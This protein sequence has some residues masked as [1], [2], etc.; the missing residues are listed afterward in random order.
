MSLKFIIYGMKKGIPLG[1]LTR[2]LFDSEEDAQDVIDQHTEYGFDPRYEHVELKIEKYYPHQCTGCGKDLLPRTVH[3]CVMNYR[4]TVLIGDDPD[5]IY[6][7]ECGDKLQPVEPEQALSPVRIVLGKVCLEC[8]AMPCYTPNKWNGY[9]MM[10]GCGAIHDTIERFGP[11][12]GMQIVTKAV[13]MLEPE[14]D[15]ECLLQDVAKEIVGT[16]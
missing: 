9:C 8:K 4:G 7:Q 15:M 13:D 1:L 10:N 3:S 16:I 14:Y 12:V 2:E 11:I 5:K 6:C